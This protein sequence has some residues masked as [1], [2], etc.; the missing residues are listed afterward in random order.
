[1]L[2][3]NTK[4]IYFARDEVLDALAE[5]I[6]ALGSKDNNYKDLVDHMRDS[7]CNIV[8]NEFDEIVVSIIGELAE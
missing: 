2:V 3:T 5:N 1:M 7:D 6:M 4:K 8:Y